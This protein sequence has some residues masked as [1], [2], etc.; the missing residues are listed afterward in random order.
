MAGGCIGAGITCTCGATEGHPTEELQRCGEQ[1]GSDGGGRGDS[2]ATQGAR[3]GLNFEVIAST[4]EENLDKAAFP[5]PVEYVLE[6]AKQKTVEVAQRL[7]QEP[8]PPDLIIGADTVVTM[9]GKIFEKPKDKLDA[10]NMLNGFSG[11]SHTVYTGVV[12]ITGGNQGCGDDAITGVHQFY[13]ATEVTLAA[14]TPDIIQSYIATGESM[15]KAGGYGIQA[16]GG[17]FVEKVNGDY[18]NVMGFPLCRFSK[19]LLKIYT[20]KLIKT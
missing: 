1:A 16:I 5:S 13:E 2:Q 11:K 12:L 17:T 7:K 9:D 15:D 4:F 8:T 19:E 14:L 6:T 10:F 3:G 20:P 18:F